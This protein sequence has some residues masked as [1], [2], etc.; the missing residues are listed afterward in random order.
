MMAR[1]TAGGAS[2]QPAV[3]GV[4]WALLDTVM[5][6]PVFP[7]EDSKVEADRVLVQAGGPV[8]RALSVLARLGVSTEL[9]AVVANDSAGRTLTAQVAA[10]GVG[11]ENV[12][13]SPLGAT[14]RAQVW[15]NAKN[16]SRT[17]AFAHG[18]G[19]GLRLTDSLLSAGSRAAFLHLDG[20]EREVA[21]PLAREVKAAGGS[22][23]LDAGNWKPGLEDWLD[24]VDLLIVPESALER[25]TGR[26]GRAGAESL[27]RNHGPQ[28]VIVTN[29]NQDITL[30]TRNSCTTVPV[31]RVTAVD[32]NGAGDVFAGG[33]L[34]G[35]ER[36]RDPVRATR[37]GA[38]L[39]ALAAS[40][41]GDHFASYAE[42]LALDGGALGV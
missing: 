35:M 41:F 21:E 25:V 30:A 29:R 1:L 19:E 31:P 10:R 9:A 11:T 32:T 36:W 18:G 16:G 12:H 38:C 39:A 6:L 7:A 15:V 20:R 5:L 3:L 22:V 24:A 42:A 37:F 34:F 8:L 27:Q 26:R 28:I 40:R 17:I 14:T 13:V 2:Q 23:S 4:G 33:V